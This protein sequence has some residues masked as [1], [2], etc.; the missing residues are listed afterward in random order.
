MTTGVNYSD[1]SRYIPQSEVDMAFSDLCLSTCSV[2]DWATS[3]H[4]RMVLFGNVL[5]ERYDRGDRSAALALI[6]LARQLKDVEQMVGYQTA[7]FM[8]GKPILLK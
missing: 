1:I 4:Q 5:K 7:N 8:N 2:V 6:S 3:L